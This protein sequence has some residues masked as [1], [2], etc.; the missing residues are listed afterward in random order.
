M[1][2]LINEKNQIISYNNFFIS[3]L[4][5]SLREFYKLKFL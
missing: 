3:F 2:E 4:F 1:N 5:S